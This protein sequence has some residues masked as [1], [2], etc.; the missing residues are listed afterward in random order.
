MVPD[1][2][3]NVPQGTIGTRLKSPDRCYHWKFSTCYENYFFLYLLYLINFFLQI[4][5]RSCS[6]KPEDTTMV[7]STLQ[8]VVQKSMRHTNNQSF[9]YGF[10]WMKVQALRLLKY[11]N[12]SHKRDQVCTLKL[13]HWKT[14]QLSMTRVH[15]YL[16]SHFCHC[17]L[18]YLTFM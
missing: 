18:C 16:G 9:H 14:S 17:L 2:R 12:C 10:W 5:T 8:S 11:L 1:S 15:T 6:P 7:N 4:R 13:S 3:N